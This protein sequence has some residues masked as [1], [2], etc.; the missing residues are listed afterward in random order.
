MIMR[1]SQNS[2]DSNFRWG[3][4]VAEIQRHPLREFSTGRP[5]PSDETVQLKKANM[6]KTAH[7]RKLLQ[8]ANKKP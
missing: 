2:N 3:K 7:F 1:F 6:S 5:T 8:D 4:D